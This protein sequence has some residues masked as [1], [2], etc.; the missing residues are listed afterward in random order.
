MIVN[1]ELCHYIFYR[2]SCD[3]LFLRF[4]FPQH[5]LSMSK[6]CFMTVYH[7]CLSHICKNVHSFP[8]YLLWNTRPITHKTGKRKLRTYVDMPKI[9][10][11]RNG[12]EQPSLN[13]QPFNGDCH[14]EWGLSRWHS[15]K[16]NPEYEPVFFLY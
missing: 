9:P 8:S 1:C 7:S 6:K 12:A 2:L 4:R 15:R 14:T 16:Y 5:S 10:A 3:S 11:L 13:R